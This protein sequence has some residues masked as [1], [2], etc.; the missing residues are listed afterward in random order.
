MKMSLPLDTRTHLNIAFRLDVGGQR[1]GNRLVELLQHLHRQDGIDMTGLDELIQ[2]IRQL[3]ANANNMSQQNLRTC[4]DGKIHNIG[5]ARPSCSHRN[6]RPGV[7]RRSASSG[8][9]F[10]MGTM[11]RPS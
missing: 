5:S 8:G 9:V 10:Y 3:H 6:G 4:F 7:A 11:A 1:L 2:R